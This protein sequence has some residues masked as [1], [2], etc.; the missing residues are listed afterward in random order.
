MDISLEPEAKS[1]VEMHID[2]ESLR[3]L[4]DQSNPV[5]VFCPHCETKSLTKVFDQFSL[6]QYGLCMVSYVF[7]LYLCCMLPFWVREAIDTL[8]EC[9]SCGKLLG[10]KGMI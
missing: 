9:G 8:H 10:R 3:A 7:G 6:L 1:A 5:E 2:L 4:K